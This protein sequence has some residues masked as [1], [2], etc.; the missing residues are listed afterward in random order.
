[1]TENSESSQ[2]KHHYQ[3]SIK[4]TGE[5]CVLIKRLSLEKSLKP[6]SI[7]YKPAKRRSPNK[8]EVE[9]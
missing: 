2:D 6:S 1:M 7:I 3:S 5:R 8:K 9:Q 4:I